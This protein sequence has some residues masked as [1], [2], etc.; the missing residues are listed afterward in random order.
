MRDQGEQKWNEERTGA[1][2]GEGEE[3]TL[4]GR[5]KNQAILVH[6]EDSPEVIEPYTLRADTLSDEVCGLLLFTSPSPQL[7]VINT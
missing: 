5:A 4:S 2:V 1:G 3:K 6:A 7:S